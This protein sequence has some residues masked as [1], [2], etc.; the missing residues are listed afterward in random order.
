MVAPLD[1]HS[2][3]LPSTYV[4]LDRPNE[5][6]LIRLTIQDRSITTLMGGVLP[7]QSDARAFH[8]VLDIACGPGGWAIQAAQDY[9]TMSLVGIDISKQMI[10]HANKRAE[11]YHVTDRAKFRVMDALHMLD[12]PAA[13]FDLVNMRLAS[14]FVRT[15]EWRQVVTEMLRVTRPDGVI[16]ITDTENRSQCSSPAVIQFWTWLEQAMTSAGYYFE[17]KKVTLT[18]HIL[19]LLEQFRCSQVQTKV[20]DLEYQAGTAELQ[21]FYDSM[22][23][24][25]RTLR[26]FLQRR[27]YLPKDYDAICQQ[28]LN[29]IKQPDFHATW[30]F[31]T[32]WCKPP[33]QAKPALS[34]Q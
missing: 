5:E 22:R 6:E 9:P 7:E 23:Y 20:I 14:S 4:V 13:S 29:E 31:L 1:P 24:S 10:T 3:E 19:T 30:S 21:A 18:G 32:I 27:G 12:F 25:F 33:E 34:N 26:S 28:A 11:Q 2:H 8:D 17:D 16:R 15:W